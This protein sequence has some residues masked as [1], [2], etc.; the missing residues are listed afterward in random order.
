MSLSYRKTKT[1]EWVVFGPKAEMWDTL[2]NKPSGSVFVSKKD[3]TKKTE[4]IA[5]LGTP[6][7][8][9]GVEH[10]YGYIDHAISDRSQTRAASRMYGTD[11][12]EYGD[13]FTPDERAAF[14]G[15]R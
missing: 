15:G 9:D 12:A 3:G 6:F 7:M 14:G 5:K 10:C 13:G 1:G 8:V 2:Y 4:R 11:M